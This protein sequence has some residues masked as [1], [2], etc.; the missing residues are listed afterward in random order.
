MG[1]FQ[2][3]QKS[4]DL[5]ILKL[6]APTVHLNSFIA[7]VLDKFTVPETWSDWIHDYKDAFRVYKF[8]EGRYLG[9]H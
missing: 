1:I 5:I 2:Q 3:H 4:T 7:Y 6:P 9:S 8:N